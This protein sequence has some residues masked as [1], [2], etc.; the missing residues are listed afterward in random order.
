MTTPQATLAEWQAIAFE[1]GMNTHIYHFLNIEDYLNGRKIPQHYMTEATAF[2]RER[3][4]PSPER[5]QILEAIH[6]RNSVPQNP[7]Q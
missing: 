5:D 3:V 1:R 6:A 4:K 2:L 7:G